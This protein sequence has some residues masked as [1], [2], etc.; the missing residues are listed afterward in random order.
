MH[1]FT[2][3]DPGDNGSVYHTSVISRVRQ[4]FVSQPGIR[5]NFVRI[6]LAEHTIVGTQLWDYET[7]CGGGARAYEQ[8]D[9][10]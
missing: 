7:R 3:L 5:S 1:L 2:V 10:R 6:K 4:V 9:F 8:A